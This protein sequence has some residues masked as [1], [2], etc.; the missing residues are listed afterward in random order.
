MTETIPTIIEEKPWWYYK[1]MHR[2]HVVDVYSN[3][4]LWGCFLVLREAEGVVVLY[5]RCRDQIHFLVDRPDCGSS[6]KTMS[7]EQFEAMDEDEIM[8]Y[9]QSTY[10]GLIYLKPTDLKSTRW[11]FQESGD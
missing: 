3:G 10:R 8:L 6:C 9:V 4:D 7:P 5:Q 11:E 1:C 2:Y